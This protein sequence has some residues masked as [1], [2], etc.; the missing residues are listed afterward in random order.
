[1]KMIDSLSCTFNGHHPIPSISE[2]VTLHETLADVHGLQLSE[3]TAIGEYPFQV[4]EVI[5]EALKVV[6]KQK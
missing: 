5:Q 6:R 4:L 1:M 2:I 3:E